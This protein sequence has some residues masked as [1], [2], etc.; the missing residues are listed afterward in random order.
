MLVSVSSQIDAISNVISGNTLNGVLI[1]NNSD[2]NSVIN[3]AIGTDVNG[4][5][6]LGNGGNG[7]EIIVNSSD[8]TVGGTT[9][10]AGNLIAFNRKGVVVG[11]GP[12][13]L[14]VGNT[15]LNNSIYNNA[16]IG[17][18]LAN[19][20]STPNHAVN[21]STGPNDFQNYPILS[22]PVITTTGLNVP[23]TLHS[24]VSSSFILQFFKNN[25]GDPE[26]KILVQQ[27]TVTTDANG[28]ASGTI[29]IGGVPLNSA[30]TATATYLVGSL[31]GPTSDTSEF[32]SVIYG[33]ASPTSSLSTCPVFCSK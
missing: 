5:R 13:D 32:G 4:I 27:L 11:D 1:I 19:D 33:V 26:G 23:W 17:I 21:P 6:N 8:N 28:N 18:D 9:L 24:R 16:L 10:A 14:S 20:G 25:P 3:N 22:T 29:S 12:T 30:I 7:V 2:D 15:I 31:T